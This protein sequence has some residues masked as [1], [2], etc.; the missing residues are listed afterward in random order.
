MERDRISAPRALQ[1]LRQSSRR[2]NLKIGEVAQN[3]V[4]TVERP[5][6]ARQGGGGP[7]RFEPGTG[8]HRSW[9]E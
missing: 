7:G 8:R 6:T 4:D 2:L 9:A 5:T 3:M 1:I